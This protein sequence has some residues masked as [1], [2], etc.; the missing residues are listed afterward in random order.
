MGATSHMTGRKDLFN[1]LDES[2]ARCVKFSDNS[3]MDICGEGSILGK[4]L[5][6]EELELKAVLYT[7]HFV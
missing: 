2:R 5:N 3:A 4:C 7:P 1:R 6:G